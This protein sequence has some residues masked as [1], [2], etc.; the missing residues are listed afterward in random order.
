MTAGRL[1]C[2]SPASVGEAALGDAQPD[3]AAV[4]GGLERELDEGRPAL[5]R[6]GVHGRR[7]AGEEEPV[8]AVLVGQLHRDVAMTTCIPYCCSLGR[9][10]IG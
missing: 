3:G 4:L 7:P 5:G 9:L 2:S 10:R 6:L 8:R 1:T